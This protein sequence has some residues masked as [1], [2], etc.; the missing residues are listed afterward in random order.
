MPKWEDPAN[1]EG[2]RY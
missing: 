2:G 1:L